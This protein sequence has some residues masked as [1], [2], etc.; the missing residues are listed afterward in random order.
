MKPPAGGL[1]AVVVGVVLQLAAAPP[2]AAAQGAGPLENLDKPMEGRSMH[3]TSTM[4]EGE[5]RR[6]GHE[7]LLPKAPPR[8]D[9]NE[10]SNMDNFRVAPATAMCCWMKRD[11]ASST[12]SG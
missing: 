11:P 1:V 7:K 9:S 10:L 8:G 12:T 5:D 2:S 6:M 4:R 3:A